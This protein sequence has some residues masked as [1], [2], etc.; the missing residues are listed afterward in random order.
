MKSKPASKSKIRIDIVCERFGRMGDLC[1]S[2][3]GD[4]DLFELRSLL[5]QAKISDVPAASYLPIKLQA[6]RSPMSGC[7]SQSQSRGPEDKLH[8]R[9]PNI[10]Q[11]PAAGWIN[12]QSDDEAAL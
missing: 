9:E 4:V 8:Y 10:R 2:L 1:Q 7:Q 6:E 11:L 3:I 5:A 12:K